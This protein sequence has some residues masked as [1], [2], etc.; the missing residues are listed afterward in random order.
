[1]V[2]VGRD[3][4]SRELSDGTRDGFYRGTARTA[5]AFSLAE[6]VIVVGLVALMLTLAGQVMTMTVSATSQATA[7]TEVNQTLRA[8]EQ[9]LREDLRHVRPGGS[10]LLIQG[11]PINAYWTQAG[12]DADPDGDPAPQT[13]KDTGYPHARDPEREDP[14]NPL[15][16]QR[17]R[18]D[19]L[20][21]FTT[22]KATSFVQ[23]AYNQGGAVSGGVTSQVQQVVYGHANLGEYEPSPTGGAP[24]FRRRVPPPDEEFPADPKRKPLAN[25]LPA[26][27]WHLARRVV[28]LLA[29]EP[30]PSTPAWADY[31]Q[32][33]LDLDTDD[34]S[35]LRGQTDVVGLFSFEDNVLR[36]SPLSGPPLFL[37][38]IFDGGTKPFARSLLD[39]TPPPQLADRLGHYFVPHCASFKVEWTLDPMGVLVGGRLN[40]EK[41]IYWIDPG[42]LGKDPNDP[43]DEDPLASLEEA[44]KAASEDVAQ[45]GRAA[46]LLALLQE[47]LGGIDANTSYSLRGRFRED[48]D[49]RS[50]AYSPNPSRPNLH[51]FTANRGGPPA[52][53]IVDEAF[54]KAL[55]ITVDV[56][57]N[58]GRLDY[59]I[60]H[61]M[62][63]PVGE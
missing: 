14:G 7:F 28:H 21:F 10:L 24:V 59:P 44:Y 13:P 2:R 63:L 32:D 6:L 36:A 39:L 51:V 19:I 22:R 53:P 43:L 61:V 46:A 58:D 8:L 23:Y 26:Q 55:R 48:P 15:V 40:E 38:E 33:R 30:P 25:S 52:A 41:D 1:M 35:I 47:P 29:T 12:K 49:W 18:A 50:T 4:M 37:P 16:L 20:M 11:N 31:S 56:W 27:E 5:A 60:R 54:P 9:T 42:D 62:V 45:E 34:L 17:P 57:D 3:V